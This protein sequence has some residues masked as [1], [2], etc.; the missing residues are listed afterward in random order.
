MAIA[1]FLMRG[2]SCP[3]PAMFASVT[4]GGRVRV[5]AMAPFLMRGSSCPGP[6][7]FASVTPGGR[8]RVMIY[9]VPLD[10]EWSLRIR[11]GVSS[12]TPGT[13]VLSGDDIIDGEKEGMMNPAGVI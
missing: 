5:M 8:V 13:V 3:G 9:V 1:S 2:S 7:I 11:L 6:A 12:G 10:V 4:P